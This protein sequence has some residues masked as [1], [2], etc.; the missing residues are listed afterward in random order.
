MLLDCKYGA[1]RIQGAAAI[2][3]LTALT[4]LLL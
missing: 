3:D 1:C 4:P 2:A